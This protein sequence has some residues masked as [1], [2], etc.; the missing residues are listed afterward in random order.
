MKLDRSHRPWAICIAALTLVFAAL[1]AGSQSAS[2]RIPLLG[3]PL[4]EWMLHSSSPR[5]T[6]G[7]KPLGLVFGG[8]AFLIF[9]F[10][11]SLGVRKKRRLWRIG[12]V[13]TWLR[14]HIWL[15]I[16]TV[17]LV[18]FHCGFKLGG[19]HTSILFWLWAIVMASGFWGL[20]MQHYFPTL[21]MKEIPREFVYEQMPNIRAA[22]FE[23]ALE[24]KREMDEKAAELAKVAPAVAGHAAETQQPGGITLATD[25]SVKVFAEFL[26]D[27]ALPFLAKSNARRGRLADQ[28]SSDDVFKLLRVNVSETYRT[29]VDEVRE[30]CDNH[31]MMAKQE[32]MHHWLHGWLVLHVPVSVILLVWTVWHI[33]VTLIYLN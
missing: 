32:R 13:Q 28:R 12:N 22:V 6:V 10:A 5:D 24:L 27:D 1:Y 8:L 4:P 15:T 17:P 2:G 25:P 3:V 20:A 19:L 11:S 23:Q 30:W 33:F 26:R 29:R 21:M 14:A 16:L 7:A 18:L 31:R 9:L